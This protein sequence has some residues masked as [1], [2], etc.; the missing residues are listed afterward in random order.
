MYCNICGSFLEDEQRFCTRCGAA[1]PVINPTPK[2]TRWVPT[3]ILIL[4]AA[5]GCAVYIVSNVG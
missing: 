4:M 2:G 3:L 5:V 1:R